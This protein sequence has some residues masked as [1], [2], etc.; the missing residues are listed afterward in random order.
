MS[1]SA[2]P[3]HDYSLGAI[4]G[5]DC[6]TRQVHP[7]FGVRVRSNCE[8]VVAAA[9]RGKGLEEFVPM[10]SARRRWSDRI[11]TVR[12]PL[13]PGYVFARFN[14][15][16]RLPVLSTPGV[17]NILGFGANPVPIEEGEIASIQSLL[18]SGF[19]AEPWPFLRVGQR[20]RL[21]GGPLQ[22]VEG[23]VVDLKQGCRLI[24]SISLLQRSIGVE[25]E[26][27]WV[28]PC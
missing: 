18:R 24:I 20:V 13:F 6:L 7:W 26:R 15:A 8:T 5:S 28:R 17:V 14:P 1:A 10:Y 11:R 19:A 27:D 9:L 4:Q 2:V 22:G 23:V 3:S 25:I 12:L 21:L 16:A